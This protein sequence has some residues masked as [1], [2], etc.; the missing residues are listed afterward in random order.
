MS[1]FLSQGKI[2]LYPIIPCLV[3]RRFTEGD[4]WFASSQTSD[5]LISFFLSIVHIPLF[6]VSHPAENADLKVLFS[7][8]FECFKSFVFFSLG[9]AYSNPKLFEDQLYWWEIIL[10][11]SSGIY[12][13][14][15]SDKI[16]VKFSLSA[17]I[18]D[19]T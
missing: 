17:L 2:P 7:F 10:R 15:D 14:L 12:C 16:F 5:V 19:I 9:P 1:P 18:W 13:H 8:L 4:Y 6:F 11:G 3:W